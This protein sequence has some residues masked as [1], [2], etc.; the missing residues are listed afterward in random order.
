MSGLGERL[1][2][3]FYK[4]Y[5]QFS[6]AN[7]WLPTIPIIQPSIFVSTEGKQ[8]EF[9]SFFEGGNYFKPGKKITHWVNF[10]QKYI[11]LERRNIAKFQRGG[12]YKPSVQTEILQNDEDVEFINR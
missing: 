4:L 12:I 3:L 8:L 2:L 10:L 9:W 6:F 7:K 1:L 11:L 5:D